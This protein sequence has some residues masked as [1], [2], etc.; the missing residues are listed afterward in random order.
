MERQHNPSDSVLAELHAKASER[1]SEDALFTYRHNGDAYTL[2]FAEAL[3]ICGQHIARVPV[4]AVLSMLNTMHDDAN[5]LA[6]Y[7]QMR[8]GENRLGRSVERG[9]AKRIEA[10]GN[11]ALHQDGV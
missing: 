2:T 3:D 7:D 8:P 10:L 11:R 6:R 9:T 5:L 1:F 4:E